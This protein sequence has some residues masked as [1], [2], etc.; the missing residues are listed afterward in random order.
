MST[1]KYSKHDSHLGIVQ[2]TSVLSLGTLASRALGFIRD[3]ILA[4]FLGTSFRADAFFV[5]FRIPNLFRDIVGE[6]GMNSSVVPV[7]AEYVDKDKKELALFL[8]TVFVFILMALSV[9][10]LLGVFF[11]PVIVRLI[12]P[13]FIA[14]QEKLLLTI[15]LTR[16]MF[17]YLIFIGLTAYGMGVLFTF[18]SFVIPAFSP[19]LL[20]IA[21]IIS[22]FVSTKVSCDPV[23]CL[24]FGVLVGGVLQLS[25]HALPIFNKGIRFEMPKTL[26][27]PGVKKV[28]RLLFPRLFGS[29]VYQLT[30]FID[31]FCASLSYVV[32]AGGI[33]EIYY[34]NRILQFP[35]AIF[36]VA[37]ANAILPTLSGFSARGNMD[38]FK[39]TLVFGLKSMLLVMLPASVFLVLFATPII[40]VLFERGAFDAYS[41]SI[42]SQA[43]LF[44]ALGLFWFSGIK[45]MVTGF[46]ALQDTVTPAKVAGLCLAINATLN[47]VL[48]GPLKVGGI[49]LASSISAGI[50][51]FI[52]FTI[53]SARLK[54]FGDGLL[55][56]AMKVF[57]AAL[58]MGAGCF[59]LWNFIPIASELIRLIIVVVAA[60]FL[61]F[62]TSFILKIVEAQKLLQWISKKF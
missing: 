62:Q 45:V 18:R 13:G 4:K 30:V 49:A 9:I 28:G 46:H 5:A 50:D 16:L 57:V 11:A 41:T 51:F 34:S 59:L 53:L 33:S 20:N 55:D 43:L 39:R 32:G 3:I 52:L 61:F 36:G 56:H 47:F 1:N 40:R 7:I 6:G 31:T 10:T 26:N 27:H 19:C 35:M 21:I 60:A 44:Y 22:A 8:N 24:A 23:F 38:D 14:D 37:L 48:M 12:A 15:K 54:G 17:P 25:A 42:T 2:T 58:V 29:A